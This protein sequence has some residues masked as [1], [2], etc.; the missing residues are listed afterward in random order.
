M[1]KKVFKPLA[2]IFSI[3]LVLAS[4]T[5][6]PL[7]EVHAQTLENA[8]TISAVDYEG[9]EVLPL[10]AVS[11]E[12]GAT[13]YDVL[14]DATEKQG[15]E[16]EAEDFGSMG[17]MIKKIGHVEEDIPFY[18]SFHAQGK[19]SNQGV[20]SYNV[21]N[22]DNL[23]FVFVSMEDGMNAPTITT[24]VSALDSDG[25]AVIEETDVEL[26]KGSTAYDALYQA[27]AMQ[28]VNL[29]V[30]VDDGLF[31]FINNI[32][33]TELGESDYWNL[34]VNDA[35]AEVG[36][37]QYQL[38]DGDAVQLEVQ[39][40]EPPAEEGEND[41]DTEADNAN[42]DKDENG[43]PE[44]NEGD[45][46]NN[47]NND[48]EE[49]VEN[50]EN[51]NNYDVTE[52]L[53]DLFGYIDQNVTLEYGSEW[54]IWG[55]A[56]TDY[57]IPDS[58]IDSVKDKIKE[59]DGDFGGLEL[60]KII[61]SLSLLGEDVTDIAG[62]NLIDILVENT[63]YPGVN[64]DI[65]TLLALDSGNYEV[66]ENVRENIIQ[67]ILGAETPN[68]G[69]A[70]FGNN[71][72][73]D[74]TSMALAALAPYQEDLDVKAATDRAIAYI[75]EAQKEN[76]GF[77]EA[78]N[79]GDSSESVSQTIVA[80]TALGLDPSGELFTKEQG[81]LLTH[82]I[83]FKQNDGGYAH[84]F[85]DDQSMAM[86]TEQA[87]LAFVAYEKFLNDTGSLYQPVA[88]N[89]EGTTGD[90]SDEGTNGDG[91]DEGTTEDGNDDGTTEDGSDEGTTEDGNEDGTTGNDSDEGTTE[92]GNDEGTTEDGNDDGTTGNGSDEGTTG[93]GNGEDT[94]ENDDS[95]ESIFVDS[96]DDGGSDENSDNRLPET[97]TNMFTYLLIGLLLI[98][99][100]GTA[101]FINKR[102]KSAGM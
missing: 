57:A 100:G 79:G 51:N 41:S 5:G 101:I 84:V 67:D 42:N 22:G 26:T 54:W 65:Y 34:S 23:S 35:S 49:N 24:S 7:Q 47:G 15:I 18:W 10:T 20:S 94:N 52:H 82:L 28:G 8:V 38:H 46:D 75:S 31:T 11:F 29:D 98:V 30:S 68:S 70:F 80:L 92:D 89:G 99:A 76:G 73:V 21:K 81:D 17:Y 32:G 59:V 33:E 95:D 86:S 62:Y 66:S 90:G 36:A 13:A 91:S 2:V 63:P 93:D 64:G 60:Q 45:S 44:G 1:N 102:R 19:Y 14:E 9:E 6:I 27:A 58:Y 50:E 71:P 3:L 25:N 39:T 43:K 56:H 85:G 97:A 83:A 48:D 87:L 40:F 69:W 61:I 78:F 53:N 77:F 37:I 96:T 16:L 55:L 12:P 4:L 88:D 72:T 74:I